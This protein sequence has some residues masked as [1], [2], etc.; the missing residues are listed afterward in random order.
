MSSKFSKKEAY[1]SPLPA[2]LSE[3]LVR[4]LLL[5]PSSHKAVALISGATTRIGDPSGKTLERPELDADTLEKNIL[6]ISNVIRRILGGT[7]NMYLN[8]NSN[9]EDPSLVILNNYDSWAMISYIC[10]RTRAL[11]FKLGVVISGVI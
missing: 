2:I 11:M 9:P 10:F 8:A 1:L 6:G 7:Q 5:G 3:R 4:T